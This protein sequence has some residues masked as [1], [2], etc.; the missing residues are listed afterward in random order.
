MKTLITLMIIS[1]GLVACESKPSPTFKAAM[2][3]TDEQWGDTDLAHQNNLTGKSHREVFD[4]CLKAIKA[5]SPLMT[6]A[7]YDE[8]LEAER[9]EMI[10][11]GY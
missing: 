11:A 2:K 7:E 9:L 4:A 5:G 6:R 3:C 1:A 10:K 8:A